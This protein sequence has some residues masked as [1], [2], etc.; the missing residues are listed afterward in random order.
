MLWTLLKQGHAG[1]PDADSAIVMCPTSL[2]LNWAAEVKKWL[3]DKLIPTVVT[4][5]MKKDKIET[6][7][8]GFIQSRGFGACSR[9][10]A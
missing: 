1:K 5:D 10:D 6:R 2:V 7:L 8:R 4:S 3:G 9:C